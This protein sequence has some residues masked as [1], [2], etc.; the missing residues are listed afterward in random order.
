MTKKI[1]IL[2]DDPV[3]L[4]ILQ[5]ALASEDRTILT[6][7]DGL[8]GF[9]LAV[10]EKPDL[11]VTD[12]LLPRLDGFELFRRIRNEPVLKATKIIL[13]SAVYKGFHFRGDIRDSGADAFVEKPL[14]IETLK[15]TAGRLLGEGHSSESK[16]SG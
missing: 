7:S 11:V 2:D 13:I 12:L 6:S 9:A 3:T 14:D 10:D 1:L 5:K 8:E 4:A 16:G 15:R